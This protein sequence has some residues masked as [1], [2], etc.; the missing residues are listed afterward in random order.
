MRLDYSGVNAWEL[1][2]DREVLISSLH[3]SAHN[4]TGH[5]VNSGVFDCSVPNA[6]FVLAAKVYTQKRIWENTS[7][8]VW[9]G[10]LVDVDEMIMPKL[11]STAA[12]AETDELDEWIVY[13]KYH[14][15]DRSPRKKSSSK[16]KLKKK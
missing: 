9:V 11:L 15:G 2:Y 14:S 6:R 13:G 1:V 7:V 16:R 5:L 4:T 12:A 3:T 10:Y 8:W